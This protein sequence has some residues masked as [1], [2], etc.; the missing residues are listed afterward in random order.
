MVCDP[1]YL[2]HLVASKFIYNV[3]CDFAVFISAIVGIDEQELISEA[4]KKHLRSEDIHGGIHESEKCSQ[5]HHNV[6]T[7]KKG[8][9]ALVCLSSFFKRKSVFK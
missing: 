3:V 5:A 2:H 1:I 9:L 7:K 4:E 8:K 6:L